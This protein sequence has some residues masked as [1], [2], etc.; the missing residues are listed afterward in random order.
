MAFAIIYDIN[1]NDVLMVVPGVQNESDITLGANEALIL[2]EEPGT[3]SANTKI[4][5][6]GNIY[7]YVPSKTQ[8]EIKQE[9]IKRVENAIQLMLD[10]KAREYGYDNIVSAC[11]YAGYD[12]PF[13]AEGQAL[14]SWRGSVW[15]YCYDQLA[16]IEAGNREE[17]TPEDFL[18]E[19]PQYTPPS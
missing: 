19:L 14:L 4:D 11:S 17:P 10:S 6:N 2:K 8:E 5:D 16:E 3:I 7:R 12:N 9:K 15:K 18:A 1:T 13:Q